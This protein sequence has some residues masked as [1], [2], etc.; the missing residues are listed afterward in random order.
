MR[1]ARGP[2][3]NAAGRAVLTRRQER[4]RSRG[5]KAAEKEGGGGS[6]IAQF[7]LL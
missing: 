1:R 7:K 6:S 2:P 4:Q 5:D 3:G